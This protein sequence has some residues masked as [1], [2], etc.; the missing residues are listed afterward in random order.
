VLIDD[1][2]VLSLLPEEEFDDW[3]ATLEDGLED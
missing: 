2:V 3:D 1:M